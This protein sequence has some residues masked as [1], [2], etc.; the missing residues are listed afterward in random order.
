MKKIIIYLSLCCFA[1]LSGS[2]GS[3]IVFAQER[4][5]VGSNACESCHSS[6]YENYINFSKKASSFERI[7]VMEQ[8]LTPDEYNGCFE[9]HTTGHGKPG[10]F[11]SEVET[12]N[13]KNAGCEV[14]HGPGS[15]HVKSNDPDDIDHNLTIEVCT[16]CHNP[17][18]VKAFDFKPLLFGGAH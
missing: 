3:K 5:Y 13:L 15:L 16:T 4:T 2:A 10:G 18:R 6:E 1:V 11:V 8:K 14:C 7:K 12:P 17:D 9:C